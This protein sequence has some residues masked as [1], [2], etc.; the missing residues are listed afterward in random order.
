MVLNVWTDM[1]LGYLDTS[2]HKDT[3]FCY[4]LRAAL[5]AGR[6]LAETLHRKRDEKYRERSLR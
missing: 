1:K 3:D 4:C 2:D 5:F 6:G